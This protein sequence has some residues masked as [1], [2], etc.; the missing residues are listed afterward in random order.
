MVLAYI[1]ATILASMAGYSYHECWEC[2]EYYSSNHQPP[3]YCLDHPE[4][5]QCAIYSGF[6]G[7]IWFFITFGISLITGSLGITKFLQVGP[8]S[9]ISTEG[10]L[11]GICRWRFALAFLSVLTSMFAKGCYIAIFAFRYISVYIL[12]NRDNYQAIRKHYRPT[13]LEYV[14]ETFEVTDNS[15]VQLCILLF[16]RQKMETKTKKNRMISLFYCYVHLDNHKS[17]CN[18]YY[19]VQLANSQVLSCDSSFWKRLITE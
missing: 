1:V 7:K 15:I 18:L 9:V 6:G 5:T 8:F 13:N 3:K 4:S 14:L 11:F 17:Y 19:T 2:E 12:I 10:P 16:L